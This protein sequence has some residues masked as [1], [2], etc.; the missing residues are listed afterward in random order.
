MDDRKTPILPNAL[1]GRIDADAMS[2]DSARESSSVVF[3]G[4]PQQINEGF[5]IALRAMGFEAGILPSDI[6]QSDT[7]SNPEDS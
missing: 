4:S 2:A 3:F 5:A 6:T 1:C 7:T